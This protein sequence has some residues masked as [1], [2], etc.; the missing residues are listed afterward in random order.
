MLSQQ[1]VFQALGKVPRT[2]CKAHESNGHIDAEHTLGLG[3]RDILRVPLD[4]VSVSESVSLW[5]LEL[6]RS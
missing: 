6:L 3:R 1:F 4:F 2:S 5:L